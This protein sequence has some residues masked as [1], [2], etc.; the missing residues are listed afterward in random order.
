[1]N[2][3]VHSNPFGG[4]RE[5]IYKE[6]NVFLAY[7]VLHS[8]IYLYAQFISLNLT[9]NGKNFILAMLMM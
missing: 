4:A 7:P 6:F 9:W 3:F 2:I 5:F 8:A 1:M